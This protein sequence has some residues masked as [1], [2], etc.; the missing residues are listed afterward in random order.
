MEEAEGRRVKNTFSFPLFTR[1]RFF[2]PLS[3]HAPASRER[4]R[5]HQKE[6]RDSNFFIKNGRVK[7]SYEKRERKKKWR[8]L[9]F[10]VSSISAITNIKTYSPSL[11]LFPPPLSPNKNIIFLKC[12]SP[13]EPAPLLPLLRRGSGGGS[14]LE[15]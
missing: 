4:E 11:F 5:D 7:K 10:L 13:K 6:E 14:S 12:S 3:A 1:H 8:R 2:L 15:D 9:V